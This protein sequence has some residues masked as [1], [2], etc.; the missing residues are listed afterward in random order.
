[1]S[2]STR[3]LAGKALLFHHTSALEFAEA[4]HWTT[5]SLASAI[6]QVIESLHLTMCMASGMW[7]KKSAMRQ[8][9]WMWFLGLGF[10]AW[11][12]SGNLMPSR[13]KN[14]GK[15]L[16]TRSQLPSRV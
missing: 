9:S 13:T 12:M 15:L 11:T 3:C 14:T 5:Y 1:M 7:E 4:A 2:T 6:R 16:P 10:S 8:P